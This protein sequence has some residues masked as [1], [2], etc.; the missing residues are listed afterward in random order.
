MNQ[1][2]EFKKITASFYQICQAKLLP[3]ER[4]PLNAEDMS[5]I[6][7]DYEK[8]YLGIRAWLLKGEHVEIETVSIE[9]D[10]T[11]RDMFKRQYFPGW[12]L[13]RFPPETRVVTKDVERKIYICPHADIPFKDRR[14]LDFIT[15]DASI[16]GETKNEK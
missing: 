13:K 4:W 3:L 2:I 6:K 15:Y 7:H 10:K 14:H 11:W 1:E 12:L 5:H 16:V 9:T 8:I